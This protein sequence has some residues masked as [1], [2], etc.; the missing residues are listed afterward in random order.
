MAGFKHEHNFRELGGYKTKDGRTVK[1]G[2][3]YR[4]GALAFMDERELAAVG[5]LGLKSIVDLRSTI[6]HI[7]FPDPPI[8]G[9]TNYHYTAMNDND[10]NEID[11]SSR[12]MVLMAMKEPGLNKMESFGKHLYAHVAFDNDAYYKQAMASVT[13][14]DVKDTALNKLGMHYASESQIRYYD[15]SNESYVRQYESVPAG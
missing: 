4:S 15:S 5:R 13:M 1:K 11:Y 12:K 10:I 2:M 7:T 8:D 14:E 9:A 6:E 3:F